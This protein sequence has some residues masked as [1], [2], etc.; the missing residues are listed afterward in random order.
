MI[1][2]LGKCQEKLFK[3]IVENYYVNLSEG[4]KPGTKT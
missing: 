2:F 1:I 4:E 3:D